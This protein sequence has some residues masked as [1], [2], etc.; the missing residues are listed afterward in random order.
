MI[1]DLGNDSRALQR[2][3]RIREPLAGAVL[4]DLPKSRETA[5]ALRGAGKEVLLHLPMEPLDSKM[6]P[7]PGLIRDS[8]SEEEIRSTLAA[9]LRSVPGAIGVNNHMGSKGTADRRTVSVLLGQLAGRRLF[10]LD[11]RT[12][13]STVVAEEGLRLGVPVLSRTVFLDDSADEESVARQLDSAESAA[14]KDGSAVA[15]G[16]P[17]PTT[18]SVLEQRLPKLRDRGITACRVSELTPSPRP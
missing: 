8:M 16:H 3:L 17:H 2:L 12:T 15:I 7:G 18:L 5:D 1:D 13:G 11:S 14:R 9:D 10:F 6:N 4:P